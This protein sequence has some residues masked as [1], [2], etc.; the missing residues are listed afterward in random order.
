MDAM[1]VK[2]HIALAISVSD[3]VSQETFTVVETPVFTGVFQL[4]V[5]FLSPYNVT[6]KVNP[7]P[8]I[9]VCLLVSLSVSAQDETRYRLD[10]RNG[11]FIPTKNITAARA[12]AISQQSLKIDGKSYAVIQFESIP[13]DAQKKQL[14]QSGITLLDYIPNNAYTVTISG[15]VDANLLQRVAARSIIELTPEQKME[16][17]LAVSVFP[18]RAV[19]IPGTIDCRVSF[20]VTFSLETVVAELAKRNITV[21]NTD[22]K[23]YRIIDV[24]IATQRLKELASLPIIEYVQAHP[25]EDQLLNN[26]VA[27]NS[28]VNVLRYVNGRNLNGE[29]VVIGIGDNGDPY[30]HIDYAGRIIDRNPATGGAHG[31]GVMG[32][33]AGGGIRDERFMGMAPKATILA[34]FTSGILRSM[35]TYVQD[36]GMVITNNSYGLIVDDCQTFGVYDLHSRILDQQ[37]SQF[38]NLQNVFA[39]G[40]SGRQ[41]CP[42][43][44]PTF[45][46][47]LGSY[48]TAKNVISVGNTTEHDSIHYV[49]SKGPVKDGRI[50]PEITAQGR[51]V[52]SGWA[53]FFYFP[54][55]GTSMSAPAV[56]GGLALLYQRYRQLNGGANPRNGLMKA[57]LCNGATDLGHTGPDYTYGFGWMNVLRSA[58]MLENNNYVT[59]SI[60]TGNTQD[61]VINVPANTAQLK[62]M[63]YWNDTAASVL[64]NH[65]L[66]NDLDLEVIDPGAFTRLPYVLDTTPANVDNPATTGVDHINNIEQVVIYNPAAGNYTLRVKG[67]A[68]NQNPTQQYFLVYD[69]IPVSTTLTY[70]VGKERMWPGDSIYI[71]WDSWGD[72]A[73]TFHIEYQKNS[74]SAWTTI[75][76][77]VDDTLRQYKWFV[78]ATDTTDEARI[79]ITRNATAMT[80]TSD[81]FTIVGRPDTINVLP[82][83][84]QCEG[85]IRVNWK[86]AEGA[87]D[88]EPMILRGSE[89][90]GVATT[91]DT[92]YTF[93]GLSKDS[94]YWVT[95]RPRLNGN[96]GRRIYA[97]SRQPNNGDCSGTISDNDIKLDSI[98]SPRSGRMLTS[99]QLSNSVP[100]TIR[101][102]NLDDVASSSAIDVSYMING[103]PAV[104][105]TITP[106]IAPNASY[107][108]TFATNADLSAVGTYNFVVTATKV[109]DPVTANNSMTKTVKQLANSPITLASLPWQ[110]DFESADSQTVL[111]DQLGLAG[112]DRYD[113][114]NSTEYGRLR[115]FVNTGIARSGTKAITLD[116]YRP[117][118]VTNIDSLTGTFNLGTF[119]RAAD[120]LRLDFNYKN[121]GQTA[122]AANR[123]WVRGAD[124]SNWIQVYNLYENQPDAD[125]SWRQTHSIELSDSLLAHLQN[126][127]T[128]FQVRFGQAGLYLAAD[129]ETRAGYTF[130]DIRIYRAVDDINMISIDTPVVSSCNLNNN[131]PVRITLRNAANNA[132][133]NV[134]VVL[135]VDGNI[136][137]TDIIPAIAANTTIQYTFTA[138]APLATPGTHTIEVWSELTSDTYRDNDTVRVSIVNS[139]LVTSYPYLQNFE[140]GAGNWYS[141]GRN[142]SWEFGTPASVKIKRAASGSN[143]WKT[144]LSGF[145]NDAELSYL[146]SP[147]F[148]ISGMTNPTLSFSM[149]QDIEECASLCDGAWMEYSTNGITWTKLGAM[150][151]GYNWYNK[152]YAGNHV[153]SDDDTSRWRVSTIPL[154]GTNNTTLRLRFVFSSD[155]EVTREGI[156]IDDIHIYDNVYGIYTGATM[157]SPVSQNISGGTSWVDF[158][159]TDNKLVASIQPNNQSMGNTDVQAYIHPGPGVRS[160]NGQYYHNRNITIKPATVALGDSAIVRFYFLDSETEALIAATGCSNCTKPSMFCELGVSKYSDPVDANEDGVVE[161]SVGKYWSFI[162]ATNAVKVPFDRGYYAEFKVRNFS[163]FWL[164]NGGFDNNHPLPVE[165]LSFTATKTADRRNVVANWRTATEINTSHF[166]IEVARGNDEYRQNR[167]VKIGEVASH[168]NST[169]EQQYSFTD[170]ENNKSGVRY[171]RLKIVDLDGSFTY[172]AIRPVVFSDDV[173]WQVYPNP[174]AGLFNFVYQLNE[175]ERMN[176]RVYDAAGKV[177]FQQG[178]TANGFLQKMTIDMSASVFASGLYLIEAEGAGKKETFRVIKN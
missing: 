114:Y 49:S 146:Y 66:V 116:M 7:I 166:D 1:P 104:T 11:S 67:T 89:M 136:I 133:N 86:K 129:N 88:Y 23:E 138:P 177:V 72:P 94:T 127:S 123:V 73:N 109:T 2:F 135:R 42:P 75:N 95:V 52:W 163:E 20:P 39:A 5:L 156:A 40:N 45:G 71:S 162:N 30:Q 44:E 103:G 122:N 112:R 19:K 51:H 34:Q 41:V 36:H 37:A 56:S 33:A 120:D 50:K 47:V 9:T 173:T 160:Y 70:P 87:T 15:D 131:V 84:L 148:D 24:R 107:E 145:Y 115:T 140:T 176:V 14:L 18:A 22:Y 74:A 96:P 113:F 13:T 101:L 35:G 124:T 77:N 108:H 169:T 53:G 167:F 4:F 10:L 119:D 62:V 111:I 128:S 38:P 172:S 99:T 54:N 69:P 97:Q 32:I 48:Q 174:S 126:Y 171:Y 158:I 142:S 157:G 105:E 81:V 154:P 149:A 16:P 130:D 12:S 17:G 134:P 92:F 29:G 151:Q 31:V 165:L 150:G 6:M 78:P 83:A 21:L 155:A 147:C 175:G 90:V 91:V 106:T 76:N 132:V 28:R 121:H 125:G 141:G 170:I 26:K 98:L 143:A 82:V 25:G 100:V 65:A 8:L 144:T 153:W 46:N 64:T 27:L 60:A 168:G 61:I 102:K 63:L 117:V 137:T 68:I 85:Y 55:T 79:R 178:I 161:N 59:N 57:L 80:S 58:I 43:Y 139:P 164:N 93:T 118:G 110:D 152:N 159:S 3:R